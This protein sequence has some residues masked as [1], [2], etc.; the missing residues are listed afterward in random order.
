MQRLPPDSTFAQRNCRQ[1]SQYFRADH[2][3]GA[4]RPQSE[5]GFDAPSL[6]KLGRQLGNFKPSPHEL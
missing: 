4:V 6:L 3:N 2:S 5:I 1:D